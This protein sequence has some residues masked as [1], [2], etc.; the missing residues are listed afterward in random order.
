[1]PSV[2]RLA[3]PVARPVG[4]DAGGGEELAEPAAACLEAGPESTQAD[5]D[6]AGIGPTLVRNAAM[7]IR[8]VVG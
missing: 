5:G 4:G 7:P 6:P 8:V 1:M 3:G 2:T